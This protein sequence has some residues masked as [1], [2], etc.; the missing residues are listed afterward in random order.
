MTKPDVDAAAALRA[1][2]SDGSVKSKIG[3]V[4]GLM[5]EIE[6]AQRSGV[7]NTKIVETLNEKGFGLTLK[8]FE[9]MLYRIRKERVFSKSLAA[10]TST[11]L[12]H[13]HRQNDEPQTV[14]DE[15]EN[16]TALDKKQRREKLADQ[17]IKPEV[18]N[19]L[20]RRIKEKNK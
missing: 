8:S 6:T 19:P 14:Q 3:R 5:D 17:F 13:V 20:I 18:T 16:S 7:R 4:R 15:N 9:M 12:Q 2:A 1:L 10:T 11:P